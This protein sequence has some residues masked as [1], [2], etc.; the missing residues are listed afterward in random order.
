MQYREIGSSGIAVSALGF[1][2]WQLGGA[3]TIADKPLS[4]GQIGEGAIKK[5]LWC[6]LDAGITFFDTADFYGLGKSE[7]LLGEALKAKGARAVVATKVGCVP[8]GQSGCVFDASYSHIIASCERSLRR[9]G[10]DCIDVYLLHFVPDKKR[11]PEAIA[12]FKKLKKQGKIRAYGISLAHNFARLKELI[13]DFKI[14]EGYYNLLFREF[15]KYEAVCNENNV[16]F[17]AASPLARGLLSAKNYARTTFDKSDIRN[18]WK[19]KGAQHAW[20]QAQRKIVTE[21]LKLSKEFKIPLKNLALAFLLSNKSVSV[22][23]PGMKSEAQVK[24]LV[25]AFRYLPLG[26]RLLKALTQVCPR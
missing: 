8:D 18:A 5:A 11:I 21:L 20:Y 6:A 2:C 7:Y 1:G 4:Y 22:A 10:R 23:I 9:L 15:E 13:K 3:L 25:N 12:A 14:I 17:I 19:P 24:E 26:S 16:G